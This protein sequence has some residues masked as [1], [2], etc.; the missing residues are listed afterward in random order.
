MSKII[1]SLRN[2]AAVCKCSLNVLHTNALS[3]PPSPPCLSII[4]SEQVQCAP[5]GG[6]ILGP[7]ATEQV[8][9]PKQHTALVLFSLTQ[10]EAHQSE[11][12]C[13]L[14]VLKQTMLVK[15]VIA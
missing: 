1:V 13:F 15:Q 14:K 3:S 2:N 5:D 6:V 9:L 12:V 4:D 7:S 11:Q 10:S 8:L